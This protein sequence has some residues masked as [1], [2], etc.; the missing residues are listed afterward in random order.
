V[1]QLRSKIA[2]YR[3]NSNT[4]ADE[5]TNIKSSQCVQAIMSLSAFSD[6]DAVD[7]LFH[8]TAFNLSVCVE[9]RKTEKESD[10]EPMLAIDL[11]QLGTGW[12]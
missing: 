3:A 8:G 4:P 9:E 12:H 11:E 7:I 10:A 5:I 6:E 2:V 1:E